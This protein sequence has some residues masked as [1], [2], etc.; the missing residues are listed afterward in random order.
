MMCKVAVAAIS[1]ALVGGGCDRKEAEE[2]AHHE[3]EHHEHGHHDHEEESVVRGPH[4]GRLFTEGDI[5]LELEIEEEDAPPQFV[6]YLYDTKGEHVQPA[7]ARLSV[8]LERFGGRTEVIPFEIEGP[9]FQGQRKVAEPHSYAATVQLERE[10][11]THTWTFEQVEQRVELVPEAVTTAGIEV[12][13][14]GP[15]VIEVLME[16]PGEVRLNSEKSA[17]VRPRYHGVVRAMKKRL[18]DAVKAGE[19]LATVHS[20]ESLTDYEVISSIAGTIVSRD[21]GV[22]ETVGPEHPLYT[23]ANL[24]TVWVDFAIYPQRAAQIRPGLSADVISTSDT[25]L[26][27]HGKVS[28]VGPLLEQ[29]TRVS[30]GRIVISNINDR[31]RPGLFVTVLVSVDQAAVDVAVPEEAIIRSSFGP[32]VFRA[33]DS[34]FEIQPVERGRTDGEYTEIL[35]GLEAGAPIVV[36]N[37]VLLRAELGKSGAAHEH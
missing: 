17:I 26:I 4:G 23:V 20:N 2:H 36:K 6:A 21:A 9:R 13:P 8:T 24:S 18:G 29:D 32:A 14:A 15:R 28:Y 25:T 1:L 33:R 10:G 7:N 31:W 30:Y 35:A 16:A 3:D 11:R 5:G 34:V 22:G 37:A 12:A 27:A 19:A